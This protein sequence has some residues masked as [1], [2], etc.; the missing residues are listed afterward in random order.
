M[1]KLDGSTIQGQAQLISADQSESTG[2][3]L[4]YN[5]LNWD[6]LALCHS[7]FHLA[8]FSHFGVRVSEEQ[9]HR[10]SLGA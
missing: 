7:A 1:E 8:G 6:Y 3:W 9:K 2:D 5:G 10:T 4:V